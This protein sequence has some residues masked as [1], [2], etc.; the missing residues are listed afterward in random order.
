M[1]SN[2]LTTTQIKELIDSYIAGQSSRELS[3]KYGFKCQ[4]SITK[5]LK[6]NNVLVRSKKEAAQSRKIIFSQKDIDKLLLMNSNPQISLT[7]MAQ[8]FNVDPKIIK[9]QLITHEV[10]NANKYDEFLINK[11]DKIDT[12][13]KAYW[14]G[15]LA[16][17]GCVSEKQLSLQVAEK[18]LS[19]LL[20]F[21]NFIGVDYKISKCETNL[22]N[23]IFLGYRYVVSSINFVKSL[24][25]HGIVQNKSLILSFSNT[26]NDNL[27]RHYIRGLV[28]G[29]G[30]FYI[31]NDRLNFSLISSLGVCEKT[32]QYLMSNCALSK[33]KLD[34]KETKNGEK[35]YYLKYCGSQQVCRIAEYLYDGANVFLERKKELVYDF[36][37]N[38]KFRQL[39][40]IGD[41]DHGV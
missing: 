19:H 15:F 40:N 13:E 12:E 30:S 2:N 22:D 5:I 8:Y 16:S 11:F 25:K 41:Q 4:K 29:D 20:K 35:Y 7:E 3:K 6:Q 37:F 21:K 1:S 28:D 36:K 26:V 18:D 14:L 9:K 17:D 39:Q 10:Y 31:H 27:I 38:H 32:Q 33:T 24:E 34:E 23:K